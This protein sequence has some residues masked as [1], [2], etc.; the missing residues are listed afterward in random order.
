M[1]PIVA[2]I[3]T[4]IVVAVA[5]FSRGESFD[6][7]DAI[8]AGFLIFILLILGQIDTTLSRSMAALIFIGSLFYKKNGIAIAKLV[9]G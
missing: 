8:A 7:T 6:F 3:L 9:T 5:R 4:A 1:K 2:G